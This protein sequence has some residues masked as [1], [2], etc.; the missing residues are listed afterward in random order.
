M[1]LFLLGDSI[2]DNAAY[3]GPGGKAVIDHCRAR[4]DGRGI[5]LH[6]YA[7]DGAAADDVPD[8]VRAAAPGTGDLVVLS[9]GGN[10]ALGHQHLLDDAPRRTSFGALLTRL[11]E[12]RE[13]FRTAYAGA[14]DSVSAT[15]ADAIA[16]SIYNGAFPE[17]EMAARA[18]AGVALFNDVIFQEADRRGL[19]T[20]DLRNVCTEAAHY[21]NTIEPGDAGG[22]RIA[23]AI[24]LAVARRSVA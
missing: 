13:A 19:A 24:D 5:A 21:A 2:L 15:G 7:L 17:P 23:E 10:D 14:L 8:Q 12:Y 1:R 11:G 16:C 4:F 3:V 6:L 22:A 18:A 9:A 20:I